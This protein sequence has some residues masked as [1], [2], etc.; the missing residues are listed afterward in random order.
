M[1]HLLIGSA[2]TAEERA[3]AGLLPQAEVPP[4]NPPLVVDLHQHRADQTQ[5]RLA[6]KE[7]P[8]QAGLINPPD[9][10]HNR[11]KRQEVVR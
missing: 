11:A 6:V 2:P 7:E 8:L 5:Y 10:W 1:D 3:T 4:A 9:L